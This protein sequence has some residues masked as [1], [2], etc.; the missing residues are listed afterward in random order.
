MDPL[1][2]TAGAIAVTQAVTSVLRIFKTFHD[3]GAD[4]DLLVDNI[5]EVKLV[6]VDVEKAIFDRERCGPISLARAELINRLISSAKLKL[7]TLNAIVNR[8]L[9]SPSTTVGEARIARLSWLRQ[10]INIK[11]QQDSLRQTRERLST[12]L[13]AQSL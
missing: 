8:K 11:R 9:I 12:L 10:K 7:D 4:I 1:S 13:D 6:I 2:V 3:A 5:S